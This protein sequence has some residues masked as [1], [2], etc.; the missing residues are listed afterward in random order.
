MS[1]SLG[2]QVSAV[3]TATVETARFIL[4]RLPAD[5]LRLGYTQ[6]DDTGQGQGQEWLIFI[7]TD[8]NYIISMVILLFFFLIINHHSISG[9]G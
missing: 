6:Q 4:S 7:S 8:I 9:N 3:Q 5:P 2:S 1:N